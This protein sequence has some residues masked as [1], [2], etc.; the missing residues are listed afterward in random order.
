MEFFLL[1]LFVSI[2]KIAKFLELGGDLFYWS[3]VAYF[4]THFIAFLLSKDAE[5]LRDLN[6]KMKTQRRVACAGAVLGAILYTTGA[7]LPDK[8]ELAIIVS[9]G[10][11]YKV[12]TSDTAKE[13]GGK[14]IELLRKEIDN[15]LQQDAIG[16]IKSEVID[17]AKTA[18]KEAVDA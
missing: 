18:V 8:K 9:G 11:T 1:W 10:L 17:H 14:A 15:A 7:L 4:L 3:I 13:L 2:E 16:K 6:T 5:S 12:L